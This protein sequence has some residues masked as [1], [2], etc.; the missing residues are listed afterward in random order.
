M[1]SSASSESSIALFETLPTT[2]SIPHVSLGR[3]PTPVAAL[4]TLGDQVGIES[5]WVKRD[6]QSGTEYGGNKVRKL[7]FLFGDALAQG[8]DEVWTVGAIGSHHA[9]AT[10][11]Y[12]EKLGLKAAVLHFPQPMS[13]HVRK[14]LL[15]IST[16]HPRLTLASNKLQLP[17][18]VGKVKLQQWLSSS[19]NF[20]YIPGGG[21][22]AVGALGYVSAALELQQQIA[23]GE[24]A[25][26]DYIFVAAGTC[27]TLAG[28]ILGA[29]LAGIDAQIIGVRVVDRIM[30]NATIT[31]HLANKTA[32]ILEAHGVANV[33][34]ISSADV[35]ILDDYFGAD[36]GVPTDAGLQAIETCEECAHLTLEP[37]YTAKTFAAIVGERDRLD[38]AAK[39]VLYWH[40]LSSVDLSAR[41]TRADP[42]RDLP[43]EYHRFFDPAPERFS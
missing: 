39:N 32:K 2:A 34:R 35:T 17:Y 12:A 7:E 40:T 1:S 24:L 42:L 27:G 21:S 11:I 43:P 23:R 15:A 8:Y 31:A 16:A 38:L 26:P 20:Y 36:Y 4:P 22:S 25:P 33:P 19:H 28:I 10:A 13:D 6:D 18:E 9:L 41:V 37:T 3:F 29:K 5:L 14:N 30:T